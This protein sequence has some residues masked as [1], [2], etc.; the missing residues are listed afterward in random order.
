MVLAGRY[1]KCATKMMSY[2]S[3]NT[4]LEGKIFL[5]RAYTTPG[6]ILRMGQMDYFSSLVFLSI[7]VRVEEDR[8]DD[9]HDRDPLGSYSE[10]H[11]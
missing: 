2:V 4:G 3:I 5:R 1:S 10:K 7:C 8:R 9:G 11:C 6:C